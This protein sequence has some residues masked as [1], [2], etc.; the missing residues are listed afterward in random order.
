M[1]TRSAATTTTM[2][3]VVGFCTA[4]ARVISFGNFYDTFLSLARIWIITR[5][6]RTHARATDLDIWTSQ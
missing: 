5:R 1:E 3:T 2:T 4:S 6:V